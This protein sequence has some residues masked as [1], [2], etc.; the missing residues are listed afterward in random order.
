MSEPKEKEE[1]PEEPA[2][3]FLLLDD[4][5]VT[6]ADHRLNTGSAIGQIAELVADTAHMNIDAPIEALQWPAQP[7]LRKIGLAH[8]LAGIS[9]QG[10]KEIEFGAGEIERNPCP[11]DTPLCGV[12]GPV[13]Y[14][15]LD[16]YKRQPLAPA[17]HLRNPSRPLDPPLSAL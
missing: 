2:H 17:A 4:Q 12:Y 13:S 5:L 8:R 7:L 3:G 15:H 16:V 9:R 1:F 10:F 6:L 11:L 14:T